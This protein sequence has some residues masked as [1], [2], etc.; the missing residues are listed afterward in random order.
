MVL[1]LLDEALLA[2][3]DACQ[4]QHN[5]RHT[6]Q[7]RARFVLRTAAKTIPLSM[8]GASVKTV[9]TRYAQH[10]CVNFY[11]VVQDLWPL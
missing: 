1:W 6:V 7:Q 11:C 10:W 5:C 9:T 3:C 2:Q 8:T 4:V